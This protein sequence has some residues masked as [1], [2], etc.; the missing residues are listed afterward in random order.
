MRHATR[1]AERQIRHW[2][3]RGKITSREGSRLAKHLLVQARRSQGDVEKVA[4]TGARRALH[5]VAGTL[6]RQ[7]E[8]V[9]KGIDGL[10]QRLRVIE[11]QTGTAR[12]VSRRRRTKATVSRRKSARAR[13]SLRKAA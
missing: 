4:Q 7:L 1:E 2:V 10:S 3:K 13:T 9:Q 5:T 11:R 8:D 12:T 6:A